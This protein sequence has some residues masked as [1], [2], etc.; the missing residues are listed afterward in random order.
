VTPDD[1]EIC[2]AT[3]HRHWTFS[4]HYCP[5][6]QQWSLGRSQWLERGTAGDPTEY[7]V[8]SIALGPFDGAGEV[9]HQLLS[10]IAEAASADWD[11]PPRLPGS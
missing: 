2:A 9:S 6:R 1:H 11:S 5:H 3:D 8:E 10:W 7:T 4:V